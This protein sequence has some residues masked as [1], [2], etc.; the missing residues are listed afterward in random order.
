M[1]VL[2]VLEQRDELYEIVYFLHIVAVV[3]GFGPT[4]AY[5]LYGA[6]AKRRQG[7]EGEAISAAS[8]EVGKKL[9]Y[10]IYAVPVFGILLVL[11]S[12]D[13]YEFSQA[14]I[15][16]AFLLYIAGLVVS[17]GFHQPNLRAMNALQQ[18]LLAGPPPGAAP[19]AG[20]PPQVAEL[21]ARGKRAG[22][23]GGMLHLIL[24]LILLDMV[25]KPGL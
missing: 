20:P 1:H 6:I 7:A 24:A 8:L 11:L 4:F 21:E 5:P 3:A 2:A 10:G 17:L 25:F 18:Q 12:G 23:F 19:A 13:V 16:L 9:E 15:S 14:W 22:M